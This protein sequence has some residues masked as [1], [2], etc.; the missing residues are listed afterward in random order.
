MN[1]QMRTQ[2]DEGI[3]SQLAEDPVYFARNDAE[4]MAHTLL[5]S[6]AEAVERRGAYHHG[7]RTEGDGLHHIGATSEPAVDE[8]D[9]PVADGACDLR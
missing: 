2:L 8:D 9:H 7:M 3:A 6:G 5:A 1:Q 4:R